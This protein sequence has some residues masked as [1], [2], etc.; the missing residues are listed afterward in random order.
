MCSWRHVVEIFFSK[1]KEF[2]AVATCNGKTGESFAAGINVVVG[3]IA[4]T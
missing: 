1:I 3:V 2:R 4:A